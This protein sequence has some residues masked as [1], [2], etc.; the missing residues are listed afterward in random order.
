MLTRYVYF[1]NCLK[2]LLIVLIIIK[3]V[4]CCVCISIAIRSIMRE[5]NVFKFIKLD[6]N[7]DKNLKKSEYDFRFISYEI[8][9]KK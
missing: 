6:F 8:Y 3:F 1:N 2:N 5:K 9:I 4:F 7:I